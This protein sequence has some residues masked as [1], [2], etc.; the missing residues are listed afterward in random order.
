MDLYHDLPI[1][2]HDAIFLQRNSNDSPSPS[3]SSSS[4]SSSQSPSPSSPSTPLFSPSTVVASGPARPIRLVYCNERGKFQM[5][6]EAVS[7]LQLVKE[8]I[9]VVWESVSETQCYCR[10]RR[11][12]IP[13]DYFN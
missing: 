2:N 1:S 5:D 6:P 3:P 13:T 10:N 12:Q 11:H 8:P 9:G 7:V 4:S